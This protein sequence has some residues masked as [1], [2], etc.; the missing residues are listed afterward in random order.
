[1]SVESSLSEAI[2]M[3]YP[4]HIDE[5]EARLQHEVATLER[6]E[7][8]L[9]GK[10]SPF[11]IN[12]ANGKPRAVGA[13]VL[14]INARKWAEEALRESE[15][16]YRHYAERLQSLRDMEQAILAVR[17]P[18]EVARIAVEHLLKMI[19]C[20]QAS[21]ILFDF[22]EDT[23][24]R[25]SAYAASPTVEVDHY[26]LRI[27]APLLDEEVHLY[28]ATR[29]H[30]DSDEDLGPA[31]GKPHGILDVL[32]KA[33]AQTLGTLS[34]KTDAATPFTEEEIDIVRE[35]AKPLAMAFQ[36]AALFDRLETGRERL[37]ALSRRLVEVQ[38]AERRHLAQELHEEVCQLLAGLLFVLQASAHDSESL[39]REHLERA[40]TLTQQVLGQVRELS[41]DLWPAM[42][43]DFGLVP[44]LLWYF[45]R[46][47]KQTDIKVDFRDL[48]CEQRLE[49]QVEI[50]AYRVVQEALTNVARH[51]RTAQATVRLMATEER[52]FV[53]IKDQ[54][55]GFDLKQVM[56][57]STG[58][59][60]MQERVELLSGVLRIET[61][62]ER[63]TRI[64]AEWPLM[65]P[66]LHEGEHKK[67]RLISSRWP[68]TAV[69]DQVRHPLERHPGLETKALFQDLQLGSKR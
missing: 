38:E 31:D 25:V 14:E 22:E 46:Y 35:I 63:G 15:Q 62:P 57:T 24:D 59:S 20:R 60:S 68:G 50:A 8:E 3:A 26:G 41:L 19:P 53:E 29:S 44:T 1:M 47:T 52:L 64:V 66:T 23:V 36:N 9:P 34:L 61:S 11:P 5:L 43:N 28:Q 37:Q 6:V 51:A 42:L 39:V 58:L 21:A 40:E 18:K 17:P 33:Q 13:V 7:E 56:A 32:L 49:A 48:G 27:A 16:K 54:G 12:G 45:D 2:P 55:Q 30:F 4:E 65:V 67:T 10:G 69:W